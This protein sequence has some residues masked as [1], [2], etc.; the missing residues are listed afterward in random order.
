MF[1]RV[2]S[3]FLKVDSGISKL[4]KLEKEEIIHENQSINLRDTSNFRYPF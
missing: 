1:K 2:V 4:D 3:V